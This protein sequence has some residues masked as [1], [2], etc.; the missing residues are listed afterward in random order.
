MLSFDIAI[1]AVV[2]KIFAPPHE[3]HRSCLGKREGGGRRE[4]GSR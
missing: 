2:L 3:P 4:Q 1:L